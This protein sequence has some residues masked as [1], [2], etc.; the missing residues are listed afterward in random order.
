MLYRFSDAGTAAAVSAAISEVTAALPPHVT[1]A[2]GQIS[3]LG[4]SGQRSLADFGGDASWTGSAMIAGHWYD[5]PGQVD[6]NTAFLT[7]T[8]ATVGQ[9]YTLAYGGKHVTV[10]IAGEIFDPASGQP[11]MSGRR[12]PWWSAR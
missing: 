4:L 7:A 5:G 10:Q 2:S 1:E 12:S 11:E 6:V 9:Q 3:L 8:G